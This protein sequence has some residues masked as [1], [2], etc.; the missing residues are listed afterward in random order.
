[1]SGPTTDPIR[2][3]VEGVRDAVAADPA[4]AAAQVRAQ[5]V[6]QARPVLDLFADPTPVKTAVVVG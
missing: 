6:W 2:A 5:A 1:M 4:D 3:V